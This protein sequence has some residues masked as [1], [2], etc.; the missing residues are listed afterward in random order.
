M[1]QL[2]LLLHDHY[3]QQQQQP[4]THWYHT[5]GWT[6]VYNIWIILGYPNALAKRQ[7]LNWIG[8]ICSWQPFLLCDFGTQVLTGR[9][10]SDRAKSE[11]D[12]QTESLC[13]FN[14]VILFRNPD[15]GTGGTCIQL[16]SIPDVVVKLEYRSIFTNQKGVGEYSNS[17]TTF[18]RWGMWTARGIATRP[19]PIWQIIIMAGSCRP[20]DDHYSMDMGVS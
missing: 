1:L 6:R 17:W 19:T 11:S 13:A 10:K 12:P 20:I 4:H 2:L 14:V 3:H 18:V 9:A 7:R 16:T 8:K 15:V 5:I